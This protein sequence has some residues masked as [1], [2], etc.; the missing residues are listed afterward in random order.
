MPAPGCT[1]PSTKSPQAPLAF[2]G[3]GGSMAHDELS[4]FNKVPM[5]RAVR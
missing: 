1:H 4:Q 5:N 2:S 3:H